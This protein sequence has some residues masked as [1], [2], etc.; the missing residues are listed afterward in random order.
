MKSL[1]ECAY[2][3][4]RLVKGDPDPRVRHRAQAV[5]MV[6]RGTAVVR[7]ARE[8]RTAAH[9]VRA[10]R[11]RYLEH[12][13]EGLVDA[14]RTGRPPKLGSADLELLDEALERGPQAYGWPVTIWSV[15]DLR[16]FLW[17]QRGV[18]VSVYTIHRAIHGVG[19][20]YR[21]PRHDLRHRQDQEAVA[22]MKEVLAW[23]G[24]GRAPGSSTWSI[25][26]SARS[27]A[28]PGWQKSG[29]GAAAS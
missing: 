18:R 10:W 22:S 3:L 1:E 11:D 23:L 6:A 9:R 15:R 20:R 12:G 29:G 26:T 16:E 27:T 7:V 13:R 5:L 21:R 14:R 8:F 28:I 2:D 25:S 19:Y 4:R 24:K 17:Q